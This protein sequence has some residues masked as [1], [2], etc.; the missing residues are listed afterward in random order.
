MYFSWNVVIYIYAFGLIVFINE[1]YSVYKNTS[2]HDFLDIIKFFTV[3]IVSFP[4]F[5]AFN[6]FFIQLFNFKWITFVVFII[7]IPVCF[8]LIDKVFK[9]KN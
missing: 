4:L 3:Y 8:Y 2:N 9:E 6:N 7:T 5:I 1:L